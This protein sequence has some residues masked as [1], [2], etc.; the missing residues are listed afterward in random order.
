MATTAEIHDANDHPARCRAGHHRWVSTYDHE[1]HLPTW[2][3]QHCGVV[4]VKFAAQ[5]LFYIWGIVR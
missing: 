1:E 4:K 3:C 5:N 2:T